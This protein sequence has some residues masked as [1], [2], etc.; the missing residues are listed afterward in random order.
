MGMDNPAQRSLYPRGRRLTERLP[1]CV[2][3]V[4][5]ILYFAF[6]MMFGRFASYDEIA[7]KSPGRELAA[8]GR[9]A[10]PE[11]QFFVIPVVPS[12]N[13]LYAIQMPVY[14]LVYAGW[15]FAFGFGWRQAFAFDAAIHITMCLT[16]AL[17]L[18]CVL[19]SRLPLVT[20]AG[21]AL[22]L[23][24]GTSGR[25]DELAIAICLLAFILLSRGVRMVSAV[26]S[27]ICG[28]IVVF[29][30]PGG[31]IC[32]G[33]A[34]VG[35]LIPT[36][37]NR[38]ECFQL[39][40]RLVVAAGSFFVVTL[41]TIILL[42]TYCPPAVQQFLD[43]ARAVRK[44]PSIAQSL[45][46]VWQFFKPEI[47]GAVGF[48]LCAAYACGARQRCAPSRASVA[49][50]GIVCMAF[51]IAA[52]QFHSPL[53]LAFFVPFLMGVAVG[54]GRAIWQAGA[55]RWLI[56]VVALALAATAIASGGHLVKCLS[57]FS[58]SGKSDSSWQH[59]ESVLRSIIPPDAGVLASEHWLTLGNRNAVFDANFSTVAAIGKVDYVVL[60]GNGSG[61]A[62]ARTK[63]ASPVEAIISREFVVIHDGISRRP[64]TLFG[65]KISNSSY[66]MGS[67][68]LSRRRGVPRSSAL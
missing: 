68:I 46:W 15:T 26:A 21:A 13:E 62:G 61:E 4:M 22:M 27:G 23:F 14:P 10:S 40:R 51:V 37:L 36:T 53:Y 42:H 3:A 33:L 6:V 29:T 5:A 19:R 57:L 48:L 59:N 38:S 45:S 24:N 52:I 17:A 9:F 1:F 55:A 66:G 44:I 18:Q 49:R 64:I 41:A 31:L 32:C 50:C 8:N 28:A 12:T 63:L 30:S 56:P 7:F 34:S 39:G 25:P 20:W 35:L 2:F 60:T 54:D 58:A 11:M 67:V 47:S 43:H 16:F 65:M